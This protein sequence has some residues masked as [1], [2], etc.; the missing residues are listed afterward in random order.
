MAQNQ[1]QFDV[2]TATG[3]YPLLNTLFTQAPFDLDGTLF[4]FGPHKRSTASR[5]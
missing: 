5:W 4:E 3:N 1:P 2:L